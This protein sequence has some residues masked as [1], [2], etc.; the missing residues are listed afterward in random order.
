MYGKACVKCWKI[1]HGWMQAVTHLTAVEAGSIRYLKQ[2]KCSAFK[3]VFIL[4]GEWR[5]IR[6]QIR[7]AHFFRWEFCVAQ[8]CMKAHCVH[9]NTGTVWLCTVS[10]KSHMTCSCMKAQL[11]PLLYLLTH[12]C[13]LLWELLKPV[14]HFKLLALQLSQSRITGNIKSCLMNAASANIK[15]KTLRVY[16]IGVLQSI[17]D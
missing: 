11:P 12:V 2:C 14:F 4:S 6:V 5:S 9:T 15:W 3:N 1:I 13:G 16:G 17:W 8:S 7:I 10:W